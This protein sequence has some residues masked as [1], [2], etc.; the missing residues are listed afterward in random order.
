MHHQSIQEGEETDRIRTLMSDPI[1]EM[2]VYMCIS[3]ARIL[4]PEDASRY[5]QHQLVFCGA[6]IAKSYS[7]EEMFCKLM[8]SITV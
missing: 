2:G 4:H 8:I 5:T 7:A 6:K 1:W 3:N